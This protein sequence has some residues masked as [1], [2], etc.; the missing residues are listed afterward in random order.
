M[1]KALERLASIG[2]SALSSI[3]PDLDAGDFRIA[4]SILVD[5]FSLLREK[6]GFYAFESAL[7]VFPARTS[8]KEVGLVDWNS[9]EFWVGEYKDL[10]A[11][12]VFFAEDVFGGQ[13]CIK[14]D[15]VYL[16]DPETGGHEYLASD[17]EGWAQAI[18]NDYDVLTGYPLAHEWQQ[19]NGALAS[20]VR[21]VPKVPFVV[22]GGFL[23]DNFIALESVKAMRLRANLA[24]QIRDMPDG[25]TISWNVID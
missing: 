4:S 10:A 13:F 11:G 12:C 16:F 2:G 25:T 5:L 3:A 8:E 14:S 24:L 22:G 19:S 23:K 17:L 21:L 18:L 15:G 9:I 7:H 1:G 20:G 6:N